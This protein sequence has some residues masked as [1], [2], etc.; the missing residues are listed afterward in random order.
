MALCTLA[1]GKV[2]IYAGRVAFRF[3][4]GFCRIVRC[5]RGLRM[6]NLYRVRIQVYWKVAFNFR[7]VEVGV[8]V[9][10]G[11]WKYNGFD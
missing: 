9:T 8:V 2:H 6:L 4:W 10:E 1:E 3:H 11:V 7:T 5:C